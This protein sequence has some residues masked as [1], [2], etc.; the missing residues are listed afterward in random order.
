[1]QDKVAAIR[2]RIF[3]RRTSAAIK[4]QTLI[5]RFVARRSE[6]WRWLADDLRLVHC[7]RP[8]LSSALMISTV[9]CVP[10]IRRVQRMR[11]H[12]Q[13]TRAARK[14]QLC[15]RRF[16]YRQRRRRR[17]VEQALGMC[18]MCVSAR[19]AMYLPRVAQKLCRPCY[20]RSM[21]VLHSKG[22][23]AAGSPYD[24]Q[25]YRRM[26]AAAGRFQHCYR[27]FLRWK[28]KR[29][30]LCSFCAIQPVRRICLTCE[31][32]TCHT[33]AAVVHSVKLLRGHSLLRIEHF[34]RQKKAAYTIKRFFHAKLEKMKLYR[35]FRR[36][37]K[38][39]RSFACL[40]MQ[41]LFRGYMT[42]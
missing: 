1:V 39:R 11:K 29:C 13:H 26:C 14:I 2:D 24:V 36:D 40:R 25:E 18:D 6:F 23:A 42:R 20:H 12:R 31:Y 7:G 8:P 4:I 17:R 9:V 33:C 37:K 34:R 21:E 19:A 3:R 22:I 41:T 5:R 35:K 30:G 28:R 15:Y 16:K 27:R 10:V 32:R 38:A